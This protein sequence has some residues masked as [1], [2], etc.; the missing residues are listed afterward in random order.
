M[1]T[2]VKFS[3]RY[4]LDWLRI[5]AFGFL[6]LYHIGMFY[7]TWGW[8]VKSQY[9]SPS[10]EPIMMMVNPWRLALLFFISGVAARFLLDKMGNGRF[11]A[12][13]SFRLGV[14][15]IFGMIVVVMPQS[16]YQLLDLGE[17]QR[18]ILAFWP[19]YLDVHS[20]YSVLTPTWNHLWYII[21][22]LVYCIILIGLAP[23]LKA[24]AAGP[25]GR[26]FGRL[27]LVWRMIV[28]PLAPFIIYRY[29]LDLMFDTTHN[30]VWDWANHAHSFTIFLIGYMAAKSPVF[31]EGVRKLR[32]ASYGLVLILGVPLLIAYVNW[33]AVVRISDAGIAGDVMLRVLQVSR[34]IYAWSVILALLG[35]AQ[36]RLNRPG[37]VLRYMTGMIFPWYILHQ[38]LIIIIGHAVTKWNLSEGGEM[39][40]VFAG[41]IL[42][43]LVLSD[44]IRRVPPLRPLF[45]IKYRHPFPQWNLDQLSQ[46]DPDRRPDG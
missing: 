35:L 28:L 7:V 18:G 23:A 25:V 27:P 39:L 36:A 6:I 41:T 43:C 14:P 29:S 22:L 40:V 30:L 13:R 32:M 37:P 19:K 8:H 38:T 16:Y 26:W 11:A 4:D 12:D 20:G 2:Q 44:L 24:L 17:I 3:R 21:Y 10:L 15:L 46:R 31:W 9:S 33:D 42:G 34:I 45:G 1:N 5:I